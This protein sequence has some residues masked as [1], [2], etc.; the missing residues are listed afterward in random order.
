MIKHLDDPVS[1]GFAN[2]LITI[3][4]VRGMSLCQLGESVD[5]YTTLHGVPTMI[6]IC[7]GTN[8]IKPK[9]KV[10][11]SKLLIRKALQRIRQTYPSMFLVWS[12][13]LHRLHYKD[14]D[15]QESAMN[16]RWSLN[17]S[18]RQAA[19]DTIRHHWN[20][21]PCSPVFHDNVHLND[22]GCKRFLEN[23]REFKK[24]SF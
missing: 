21:T 9:K 24:K 10:F 11:Q 7:L 1:W 17:K 18:G 12:D 8:D 6:I 22:S 20:I 5:R 14:Y 3:R 4:A 23:I 13:I 15:S 19:Q 2:T 16:C